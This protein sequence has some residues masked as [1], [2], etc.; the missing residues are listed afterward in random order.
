MA[1]MRDGAQT[2]RRDPRFA[3]VPPFGLSVLE[4]SSPPAR[5]Y[6]VNVSRSGAAILADA[7]LGEPGV[8]LALDLP[9]HA[10][11]DHA[12]VPCEV[13]W[14]VTEQGVLPR[15]WLHGVLFGPID[16]RARLLIERLISDASRR[17]AG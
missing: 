13:R 5:A 12:P 2:T 4:D 9:D 8:V 11:N 1:A 17:A 14:V 15:R 10:A 16:S 7:V 3:L 6:L